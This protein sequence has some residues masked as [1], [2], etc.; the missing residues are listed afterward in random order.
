[1]QGRPRRTHR[2]F[3]S[4]LALF[5]AITPLLAASAQPADL[6]S[7]LREPATTL[8]HECT[9]ITSVRELRDGRVLI[10]DRGERTLH[11]ADVTSGHLTTV[12]R[13]GDGPG[14]YRMPMRVHCLG[15]DSTLLEDH[16]GGRWLYLT[17]ARLVGTEPIVQTHGYVPELAGADALGRVAE[18]R[19]FRYGQSP[20][21]PRLS[22]HSSA[23]SLYVILWHRTAQRADTVARLRG[24]FRGLRQIFRPLTKG[25]APTSV[26][27]DNPLAVEEQAKLFCDGWLAVAYLDPYRVDWR[28][29]R[30]DWVRG[31]PL[32]FE[33]RTVD[34]KQQAYAL[35]RSRGHRDWNLEPDDVPAWPEILPPFF[36]DALLA[37]PSGHLA[38][39]RTPDQRIR[40]TVYDLVD[41]RGRLAG[42]LILGE[43]EH[44]VGFGG[45]FAYVVVVDQNDVQR[46]RRHP[47]P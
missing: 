21:L 4:S 37:L 22:I 30:G 13:Q 43:N 18:V 47:W 26:I 28:S 6:A 23:E 24:H 12:G 46:L 9:W 25:G 1:M 20:G 39:R 5:S 31:Q 35:D 16:Q 32:P 40:R 34:R 45:H 11:V 19:A 7:Q 15:A 2:S 42:Q 36:N 14:E 38:I 10:L 44:L 29:P 3:A 33:A 27:I 8:A 17:G 41:R